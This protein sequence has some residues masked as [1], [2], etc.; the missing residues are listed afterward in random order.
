MQCH[1]I[2]VIMVII[3]SS[4]VAQYCLS[5]IIFLFIIINKINKYTPNNLGSEHLFFDFST[6]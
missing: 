3:V 6:I 2:G 4:V 1:S 5:I